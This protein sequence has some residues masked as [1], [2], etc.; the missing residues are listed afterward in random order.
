MRREIK[1]LFISALIL[2]CGTT[3]SWAGHGVGSGGGYVRCNEKSQYGE[4]TMLHDLFEGMHTYGLTYNQLFSK[5][6]TLRV[7]AD[8]QKLIAPRYFRYQ[9]EFKRVMVDG[10]Y[11]MQA[12]AENS[13]H[14][15]GLTPDLVDELN[16]KEIEIPKNCELIQGYVFIDN[17]Y[18]FIIDPGVTDFKTDSNHAAISAVAYFHES[19]YKHQRDFGHVKNSRDVRRLLAY[20]LSDQFAMKDRSTVKKFQVY[21]RQYWKSVHPF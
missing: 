4:I 1:C 17:D 7:F 6:S 14:P 12:N 18:R 11:F 13:E 8:L 9:A 2:F 3:L 20:A 16:N 21:R 10:L 5:T 19:L 15:L